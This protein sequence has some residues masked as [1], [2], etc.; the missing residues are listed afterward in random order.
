MLRNKLFLSCIFTVLVLSRA[1]A[2][3]LLDRVVAIVNQ[4]V[5]TWSELYRAMEAD[6]SPAVKAMKEEERKK[7]FKENE[8]AFLGTLI[9]LKLQLQEAKHAGIR[10]T[11][12][13]TKDAI[14]N[15]RKKYSMTDAQ[16]RDSLKTEGYTFEE[17]RKRLQEQIIINKVVNQQIRSKIIVSEA[18]IDAFMKTNKEF[19]VSNERY[20][21]RQIFF[22]MPKDANDRTKTEERA[23]AVYSRIL[24]GG[25]FPEL[26]RE[27]SEDS[28]RDMG[29]DLGFIDKGSL[30]KEFSEALSVMKPGDVSKPFW[31]GT[32]MHIIE[33]EEKTSV[34]SAA[35]LREDAKK[36]L[37]DKLFT[38][39][40][41][42]WIK[43]LRERAYIDVRL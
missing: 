30:A 28:S 16:F 21:L 35:D 2:S 20:R 34:K 22:K 1:D 27:Y 15:I 4:E 23:E 42:A 7:V 3:F 39:R 11:E 19:S 36:A 9:N 10:V 32:G 24:Q 33:L 25:S 17:Y 14:D 26:A 29:G 12:E 13:E 18:D 8:T 6:A 40:Y 31:T 5:I 43:S 37:S 38:E 41:N